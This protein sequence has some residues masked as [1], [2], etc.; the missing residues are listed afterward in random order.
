MLSINSQEDRTEEREFKSKVQIE[1]NNEVGIF[2]YT[3][4]LINNYIM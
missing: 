1:N 4:K 2:F 3:T